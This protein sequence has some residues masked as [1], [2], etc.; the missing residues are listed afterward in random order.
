MNI[1]VPNAIICFIVEEA[2]K[3]KQQIFLK[4]DDR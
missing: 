4:E 3:E 2:M 1:D